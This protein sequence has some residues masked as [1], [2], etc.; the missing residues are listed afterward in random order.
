MTARK[1]R[2][3]YTLFEVVLVCAVMLI[4]TSLFVPSL[5]SMHGSYKLNG[6]VDTMRTAFAQARARAIEDSRPYR[7]S[8]EPDGSHYRVAPDQADYWS[9]SPPADDPQ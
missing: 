7:V 8:I 2:S 9:G 4:G 1:R 5:R 6:A 3:G